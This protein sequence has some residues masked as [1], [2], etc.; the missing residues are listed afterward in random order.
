[1]AGSSW[2][3]SAA[4]EGNRLRP[5]RAATH[6]PWRRAVVLVVGV[7]EAR[8]GLRL[9]SGCAAWRRCRIPQEPASR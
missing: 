3:A 2:L 6:R 8:I 5:K 7:A 9:E 1:M 4:Y